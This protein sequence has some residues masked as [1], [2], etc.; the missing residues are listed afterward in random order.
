VEANGGAGVEGGTLLGVQVKVGSKPF[1]D[2]TLDAGGRWSFVAEGVT[3]TGRVSITAVVRGRRAG[4]TTVSSRST[5]RTVNVSLSLPPDTTPPR[6]T[7]D[8]PGGGQPISTAQPGGITLTVSGTASDAGGSGVEQVE[9]SLDAGSYELANARAF[10]DWSSWTKALVLAPGTHVLKARAMDKAGNVSEEVTTGATVNLVVPDRAAPVLTITRP[11]QGE[12][13]TGTFNGAVVEVEG[14]VSDSGGSGIAPPVQLVVDGREQSPVDAAP[15]APGDWMGGWRG[16]VTIAD[17]GTH[18]VE[19]SCRDNAGNLGR[20]DSVLVEVSIVPEVTSDLDRLIVVESY[21]LSSYLGNYGA[22]RTLKTFS[23]LPGEKTKIS[24]KT[25]TKTETDAKDASSILDS[26]TQTSAT[27]FETSM[28]REQ[29]DKKS[30]DE[31]F[32]YNVEGKAEAS[33][34]WGSASISGGVSGGTNA[35]REEF[36]KNI[37][38]AV[39]KHAAESSAKRDVQVNTSYEVKEETGE[40]T[41]IEREIEN[42]NVSRALNFVFRQMNQE[43]ISI[44]HLV[45]ARIGYFH[46]DAVVNPDG[47]T[48]KK[49][50]YREVALPQLAAL[51][52]DVIVDER[53]QE[54]M[55]DVLAQLNNIFDFE[56][57]HHYFTETEAF[58]DEDGNEVPGSGYLRV[59]KGVTSTYR[60]EATGSEVRVPG[61]IMAIRKVVLRTEGLMCE[62]LLGQGDGLDPYS[63]GLQDEAVRT[64][65]LENARVLAEIERE[66]L[67]QKIIEDRDTAAAEL[68]EKLYQRRDAQLVPYVITP[69]SG[70]G[71]GQPN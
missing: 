17:P 28:G 63:H 15:A 42:I 4:S 30:Y 48:G 12:D 39:E 33:W 13:F 36:A 47:T 7:I 43:F 40:E 61:I 57:R 46:V 44:L 16:S 19:A 54:V 67:A 26:F 52:R 3:D 8:P 23:L 51:L 32:K 5:T 62:A 71:D 2:A 53:R 6:V 22:G 9:V 18:L 21:R 29:S 64:K 31:S 14:T 20:S 25:F 45:D 49:Y 37:S 65:E 10:D 70:E 60:D 56:D 1:A 59:K 38:N 41:S 66:R 58:V 69:T 24:V 35:A 11:A 27:N 34:G 68:F 55:D 50:T